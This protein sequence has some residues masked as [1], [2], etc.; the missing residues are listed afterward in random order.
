M[1]QISFGDGGWV[2]RHKSTKREQMLCEME[3]VVPWQALCALIA[4]HYPK[5]G[6]PGRQAYG[7]ER[8]LRVH[9]MQQWFGYSDP[10]MEEAL[11]E[12]PLLRQ[13]AG[14]DAGTETLPDE[15]TILKFRHLLERHEIGTE[16]FA[17]IKA[18]LDRA[19]LLLKVGSTVDATLIA[20]PTS[21][22]NAS[23]KRDPEMH[24]SKKGK[25]WHFGMKAH[26]SSELKSGLVT[27]LETT[28]G[29]VADSAMLS[30]L[31][32]GE[33]E[34]IVADGGYHQRDRLPGTG[35]YGKSKMWTPFRRRPGRELAEWQ[36]KCNHVV[37]S[38]RAAGEHA[39]RVLKCQF[40][41]RKVR[42]RGLKKNGH[43]LQVMFGLVNLYMARKRLMA[44]TG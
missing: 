21:T 10:G 5:A 3:R 43:Q 8:M 19:G 15:T 31:V 25:D 23:G 42:Y 30:K 27:K 22:K 36:R 1:K 11:H 38:L 9:L 7:L 24:Q 29:N 37:A 6:A 41:Y 44:A 33:E 17:S 2:R 18:H 28:A 13:F 4:P 26:V 34:L 39:F 35:S 12:V 40:G 32:T 14:F 16:I 20:A